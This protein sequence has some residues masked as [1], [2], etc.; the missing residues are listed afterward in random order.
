MQPKESPEAKFLIS[1]DKLFYNVNVVDLILVIV[2]LISEHFTGQKIWSHF[3]P[4]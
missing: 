4:F 1:W 3:I 2:G